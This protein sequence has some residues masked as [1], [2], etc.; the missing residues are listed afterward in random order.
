LP[1]EFRN[2]EL[3]E[4]AAVSYLKAGPEKFQVKFL[5]NVLKTEKSRL[6][7]NTITLSTAKGGT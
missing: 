5:M 4:L 7:L 2:D 1:G 6:E 3:L